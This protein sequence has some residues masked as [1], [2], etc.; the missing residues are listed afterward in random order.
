MHHNLKRRI[1]LL[2]LSIGLLFILT[3]AAASSQQKG[4][5]NADDSAPVFH[6]YKG[7]TLGMTTE[8]ARKKLGAPSDKDDQQDFFVFNEKESAQVFYDKTH[9]VMALSIN[10]LGEAPQPK[11][12]L[13]T[14]VEAK[15]DGS[16]YQLIRYPKAGCWVSYSRTAGDSPL[17][18]VTMQ[19]LTN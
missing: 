17:V 7:V 2:W 18:T 8:E 12:I 6:E 13:G 16:M 3:T 1:S 11:A 14:D 5:A 15:P 10:Y 4:A 9:K 19:K